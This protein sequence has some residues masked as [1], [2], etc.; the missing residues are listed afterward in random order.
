MGQCGAMRGSAGP[1]GAV[2]G[3]VGPCG[4][5]RGGRVN[6]GSGKQ[7]VIR[8]NNLLVLCGGAD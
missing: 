3:L 8:G 7:A 4:A 2:R 6:H 1:C 5:L